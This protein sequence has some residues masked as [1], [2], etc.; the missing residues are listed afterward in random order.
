M[1]SPGRV[2][3]AARHRDYLRQRGRRRYRSLPQQQA[4]AAARASTPRS[5]P[6]LARRKRQYRKL[7]CVKAQNE[8]LILSAI[9]EP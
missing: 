9:R 3:P 4:L 6:G 7:D 8:G 5:P 2:H 1:P